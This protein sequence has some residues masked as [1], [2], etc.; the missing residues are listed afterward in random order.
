M[1]DNGNITLSAIEDL[2]DI[3]GIAF[4]AAYRFRR[5]LITGPPGTGKTRLVNQIKGWPEEGY[6]DM[7]LTGWWRAQALNFRPREVHLGMPFAGHD[8]ALAVFDDA[9]LDAG[10]DLEL[11][12]NRVLLPPE[13]TWFFSTGWR[14]RFVF[15]FLLPPAESIFEWRTKRAAS[16]THRTDARLSLDLIRRQIRAY[17]T[18]ALHFQRSG[19]LVYVRGGDR[20]VPDED[21]RRGCERVN[22]H[23]RRH[24][25]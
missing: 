6:I 1:F 7:T 13:K 21:S 23:A 15:E 11:D 9:W 22:G 4:P 5:F 17:S 24:Q 10:G 16:G 18:I 19:I 20:S 25:V 12:L 14:G 3:R 8:E 2:R